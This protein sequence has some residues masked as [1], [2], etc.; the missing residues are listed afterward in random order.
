MKY[1]EW[2]SRHMPSGRLIFLTRNTLV[3]VR[4]G[5]KKVVRIMLV[6]VTPSDRLLRFE[7]LSKLDWRPGG[8]FKAGPSRRSS[9][10]GGVRDFHVSGSI[11]CYD[12]GRAGK[13][14]GESLTRGM[15]RTIAC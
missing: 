3:Y 12:V 1:G 9:R 15:A 7:G 8:G 13:T 14:K 10:S 6:I 2:F 5:T 11:L 4:T